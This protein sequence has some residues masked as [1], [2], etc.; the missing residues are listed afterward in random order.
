MRW[1]FLFAVSVG[2]VIAL[3]AAEER[4]SIKWFGYYAATGPILIL[5]GIFTAS[6][7]RVERDTGLRL[8]E[9]KLTRFSFRPGDPAAGKNV[10]IGGFIWILSTYFVHGCCITLER[11]MGSRRCSGTPNTELKRRLKFTTRRRRRPLG[12]LR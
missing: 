7:H 6:D 12:T 10:A 3:L 1:W 9:T 8:G 11:C 2:A 4:I 5:L